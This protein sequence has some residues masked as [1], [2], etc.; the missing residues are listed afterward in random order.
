MLKKYHKL[1]SGL[2]FIYL[3]FFASVI[4]AQIVSPYRTFTLLRN[5]QVSYDAISTNGGIIIKKGVEYGS[6][7]TPIP[8]ISNNTYRITYTPNADF[9]GN[10]TLVYEYWNFINPS[11][12][13]PFIEHVIFQV[14]PIIASEDYITI[15]TDSTDI[16]VDVLANDL[17]D[18]EIDIN[19][20]TLQSNIEAVVSNNKIVINPIA[21][22]DGYVKYSV[23][24]DGNNCVTSILHIKIEQSLS[25]DT[26]YKTEFTLRG[27]PFTTY[28]GEG[29]FDIILNSGH[30]NVQINDGVLIFSPNVS[31][32]GSDQLILERTFQGETQV[33]HVTI[34]I[35]PYTN[36][37]RMVKHDRFYTSR[38]DAITINVLDND[39]VTNKPLQSFT[40][41]SNGTLTYL[42]SGEFTYTPNH[43]FT[44]TDFFT[45]KVCALNNINCEVARVDIVVDN[46]LPEYGTYYLQT[47]QDQPFVFQYPAPITTYD[48]EIMEN[49]FQGNLTYYPGHQTFNISGQE[50]SGM[51][52]IVYQ[53]PSGYTGTDEMRIQYCAGGACRSV[54]IYMNVLGSNESDCVSNCVW[55]G[56]TN[57]D[58]EV[59]VYDILPI[60]Y[61]HGIEDS[62]RPSAP[63]EFFL[64]YNSEN[65]G[66]EQTNNVDIKYVDANG[67]GTIAV[68]D[69]NIINEFYSAD[70][71]VKPITANP[72]LE[73][74]IILDLAT[75]EVEIGETA[76]FNI[77]IGT[78]QYPAI[79]F[80]G[81]AFQLNLGNATF[82][83][84]S[85][86]SLTL[87]EDSWIGNAG[88]SINFTKK[89]NGYLLDGALARLD[90]KY[91]SGFGIIGKF[92]GIIIRDIGGFH[93][94]S[95]DYLKIPISI[96]SNQVV[97]HDGQLYT[98][99]AI[100]TELRVK[101]GATSKY[102]SS[103]IRVYP[104]PAKEN[105]I[106]S[107][108][109]E[110]QQLNSIQLFTLSGNLIHQQ[111]LSSLVNASVDVSNI[112]NGIYIAKVMTN[113]GL[114]TSKIVIQR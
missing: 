16:E 2:A 39:L 88:P 50:V 90:Q 37:F 111:Q 55:P 100:N 42:G 93:I 11:T 6:I 85:T 35:L 1:I 91:K 61:F 43:N 89:E 48:W 79:D 72:L 33:I 75:P 110:N 49:A 9:I 13:A 71:Q 27:I 67:D 95:G 70:N 26:I 106:V 29:T 12:M 62:A 32:T 87:Y 47:S 52:L 57:A 4:N 68:E 86:L 64:P 77:I 108:L 81:L 109:D 76:I 102:A 22:G 24:D 107:T 45:Y 94:G 92:E 30:G 34:Q 46:F 73:V 84:T 53:P 96:S 25:T 98:M 51:N 103:G 41:A 78:A 14:K 114:H 82:F 63:E 5:D 66:Q 74:P 104:N 59:N 38:N 7:T 99:P 105:V 113:T 65:W 54:K 83:D 101:I 60:A 36:P 56:D 112:Q 58:G 21:V 3:A 17:S 15:S 80:R 44:G 28:L 31:Y 69:L 40:Q 20:I 97:G 18:G 8:R 10:D 19:S 23:C